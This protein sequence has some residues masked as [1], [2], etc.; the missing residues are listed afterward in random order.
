MRRTQVSFAAFLVAFLALSACGDSAR[1]TSRT[2]AYGAVGGGDTGGTT[3]DLGACTRCH[4]DPANGNAAPPLSTRGLTSTADLSVGAHQKHLAGATVRAPIACDECHV[5]PLAVGD[6]GHIASGPAAVVFGSPRSPGLGT[7]G[8]AA[9]QWNRADATCSNV[10]CHGGT[11]KA[12]GSNTAPRWTGGGA[13][14]ACGTC[15]AIPSSNPAHPAVSTELT[16]CNLCHPQS[17]DPAGALIAGGKH[18]DGHVDFAGGH[19]AGWASPTQHGATAN[20]GGLA[21]CQ[22]CH[23]QDLKGATTGVSCDSCHSGGT[24]WRTNCTFCHGDASRSSA[25]ALLKAAPPQSAAGETATTARAVGAHQQHLADGPLAKAIGCTECHTVPSSVL[26]AGHVNGTREVKFGALAG[27]A[28]VAATWNG[29]SGGPATCATYCH[30]ATLAGGAQKAPVWTTVDGSQAACGTCHGVPPPTASGAHAKVSATTQCAT[31][32]PGTIDAAGAVKVAGGLHVN[33]TV[34]RVAYHPAGWGPS[35]GGIAHATAA[36]TTGTAAC[37]ACHGNA[38]GSGGYVNVACVSC[39]KAGGTANDFG[40]AAAPGCTACHGGTLTGTDGAGLARAPAPPKA[41]VGSTRP[42]GAH[43]RHLTVDAAFAPATTFSCAQCHQPPAAPIHATGTG[44][45]A[46]GSVASPPGQVGADGKPLA[47]AFDA[48]ANSCASTWC[49]G[50]FRNGNAKTMSWTGTAAD[51]ACGSCHGLP[52]AGTHP[53][54]ATGTACSGCHQGY[55]GTVGG[56]AMAFTVNAATHLD[57]AIQ[58]S[59]S[60]P[61]GWADPSQ[62]GLQAVNVAA[63]PGGIQSCTACHVGFESSNG[64]PATSCNACH[65]SAGHAAW[66]TECTFCHG[67]ND[68]Q[69]GA[70]ARD[71]HAVRGTVQ[72]TTAVTV[73]AHTSHVA[74]SHALD[75]PLACADCHVTPAD[76]TDPGHIDAA[77]ATVTFGATAKLGGAA[78]TWTRTTASCATTYCHGATLNATTTRGSATAPVWTTVNGSQVTCGSCHRAPPG[79]ANH[80]N[81][82]AITTCVKCHAATATAAGGIVA[83]GGKHIDGNVDATVTGCTTC[84][85]NP[86]VTPSGA[87]DANLAAAPTGAGAPDTFGNTATTSAGVGAHAVHVLGARS[88]AVACSAC[89]AVPS[90][91]VHKSGVVTAATLTFGNLAATGGAVSVYNADKTC[92]S[93]YC[94]G[95]FNGGAGTAS[96]TPAWTAAGTLGCTSCHGAPPALPHPQNTTCGDC[97]PGYTATTVNVATH[98]DGKV[99]LATARA[100]CTSCHGDAARVAI[101]GADASLNAAP[102]IGTKGETALTAR[103]VGAHQAHLDTASLRASPIACSECH[104]VPAAGDKTHANGT[105]ALTFGALAKTGGLAPAWNTTALTC[106]STYCHGGS[107][108]GGTATAPVWTTVNGTQKSCASCHGAPPPASSGHVQRT[109]CGS[110]HTGYTLTTVNLATHING[111]VDVVALGCTTCH[112]DATRVA[113]ASADANVAAAPPVDTK[114]NTVTTAAGVG[115][116]QTHVNGSR[117]RPGACAECHSGAVPTTTTGHTKGTTTVAFGTLAKTGAVAPAYSAGSCAATYCHGNFSGG[118][119][120]GAT[121]AFTAAGTLGCISCHGSPPALPHPQDTACADC[122]GAGYSSTTVVAATHVDG[123]VTLVASHTGCTSC[124]GD[125]ARTG[126]A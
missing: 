102:P 110:C 113:V 1:P 12:G 74:A 120:A 36:N 61:G 39:H 121:P 47:P 68:N 122:H 92:S 19:P 58:V 72:A 29:A 81:A 20:R 42:A 9:P 40:T 126:L 99:D 51:A 117:S 119:G 4:G 15:H 55:G 109:D 111:T 73:G 18:L 66:R 54:L 56:A 16:G 23:G 115:V 14:A 62:H 25:V 13:E 97:H 49:H 87:Q 3:M 77:T 38:Q 104:A 26:D 70:P 52:P 71:T 57:G 21:E 89:H 78:P 90:T 118:A 5:V 91:P 44:D 11:L 32:H 82:A 98:V 76:A 105:A 93:S 85:G 41:T 124:H 27:S 95:G 30:G 96:K 35:T 10:Y 80:H 84:H 75:A 45:L 63:T 112:G 31:C 106:A 79:T 125:A 53:V 22:A 101:A 50:N 86:T 24:A 2:P 7:T 59:G 107:L 34:D 108:Q 33:G 103:A 69:T 46:W 37:V 64:S 94:H 88:K 123:Q 8:G 43:A 48:A 60:H 116:H 100:G 114:G 28:G 17:V 65:A 6:A 67:G 83:G